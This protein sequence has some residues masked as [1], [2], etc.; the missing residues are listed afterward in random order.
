MGLSLGDVAISGDGAGPAAGRHKPPG[1]CGSAN[2]VS[3]NDLTVFPA[4]KGRR[5]AKQGIVV[6]SKEKDDERDHSICSTG[7]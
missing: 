4:G 1:V 2:C 7:I 5:D 3:R 6:H